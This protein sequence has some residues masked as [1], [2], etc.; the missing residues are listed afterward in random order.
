MRSCLWF[1]GMD[2]RVHVCIIRNGKYA[3]MCNGGVRSCVCFEGKGG[4]HAYVCYDWWLAFLHMLC[5]NH[6]NSMLHLDSHAKSYIHTSY[7]HTYI[8]THVDAF[9]YIHTYTHAYTHTV[10]QDIMGRARS[11]I[12]AGQTGGL[13]PIFALAYDLS[14]EQMCTVARNRARYALHIYTCIHI[15]PYTSIVSG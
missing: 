1:E 8:H 6:P 2:V 11:L 10:S 15:H 9:T 7:I 12:D 13:G 5:C 4:M 3:C 14:D